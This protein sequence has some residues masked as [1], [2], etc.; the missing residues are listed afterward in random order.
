M[1]RYRVEI[2]EDGVTL[3]SSRERSS[4]FHW[5]VQFLLSLS[6]SFFFFFRI[7]LGSDVKLHHVLNFITSHLELFQEGGFEW[8]PPCQCLLEALPRSRMTPDVV[9]RVSFVVI[10]NAR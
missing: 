5:Q 1:V 4:S 9:C 10:V 2:Y 7:V 8:L 6:L 3:L